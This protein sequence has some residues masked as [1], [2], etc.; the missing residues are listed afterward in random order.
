M[1]RLYI[2]ATDGLIAIHIDEYT[3]NQVL[4]ATANIQESC[5]IRAQRSHPLLFAAC[6][7]IETQVFG[8]D[9]G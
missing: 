9:F 2:G 1:A 6:A 8:K 5:H 3:A 4:R 7:V